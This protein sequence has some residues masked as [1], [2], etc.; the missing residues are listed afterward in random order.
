MSDSTSREPNG[1][2]NPDQPNNQPVSDSLETHRGF[3]QLRDLI[4]QHFTLEEIQGLCFDLSVEF[5]HLAGSTRPLKI[6]NLIAHLGQRQR[7]PDLLHWLKQQ[8]P[9][10]DWAVAEQADWRPPVE[11]FDF[12]AVPVHERP[13]R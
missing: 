1:G 11:S 13:S 3:Q 6:Q 9:Q 5:E 4:D 12:A 8:R 2:E 7:L 10:V